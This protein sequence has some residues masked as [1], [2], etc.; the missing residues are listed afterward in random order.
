MKIEKSKVPGSSF[1]KFMT[2]WAVSDNNGNGMIEC[3]EANN[4]LLRLDPPLGLPEEYRTHHLTQA[5]MEKIKIP[6]YRDTIAKT[7]NYY[8]YDFA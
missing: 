1:E 6:I 3:S 5:I 4:M 7:N 2:E 8:F